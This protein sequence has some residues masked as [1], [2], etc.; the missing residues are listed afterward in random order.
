MRVPLV[1][2][3]NTDSRTEGRTTSSFI[4]P[5]E[6]GKRQRV[7]L[8]MQQQRPDSHGPSCVS[9]KS[10]RSKKTGIDL[11]DQDGQPADGSLSDCNL[12]ERGCEGLS[13]ALS[14]QSSSLRD[15]DLS[16]N[17]LQDSGVE[18]LSAGLKSP[19]CQLETLS[20]SGCLV[21]DEGCASLAS[22]LS[23]NP[24]HLRELDLSYN[25]PGASGGKLLS[26]G[27]EDPH[28]RLETLRMD[29]GGEQRLKAGLR[30]YSCELE[31]DTNTVN[32]NL[33]LSDD[34]RT[35]THVIDNQLY[36]DHPDR[37][38]YFPQLMCRDV[39]TGRCYCEGAESGSSNRD[40]RE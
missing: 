7:E 19:H 1:L 12:T 6:G 35:V 14:S 16:E 17:Q 33:K 32:N 30:K 4:S 34:N 36:P 5:S 39:V 21:T 8:R 40:T 15:L 10:D 29:H 22:A 20:L 11:T 25:H 37:F 38:D 27:L 26:A 13:S 2:G 18:H 31:L 24:S 28:W 3:S 23:S 9:M